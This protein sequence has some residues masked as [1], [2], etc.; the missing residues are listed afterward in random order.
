MHKHKG[1]KTNKLKQSLLHTIRKTFEKQPDSTLSH[2]KVCDL[3]DA[4]DGALRTLVF[5]ILKE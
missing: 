4:R 2:K 3:V 1:K 5:S